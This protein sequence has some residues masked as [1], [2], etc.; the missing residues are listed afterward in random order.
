M[1]F[2]FNLY[3]FASHL[4]KLFDTTYYF[5][6]KTI[7]TSFTISASKNSD[8]W[9]KNNSYI[10]CILVPKVGLTNMP[11]VDIKRLLPYH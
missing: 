11:A 5:Y 9:S 2:I 10:F 7:I 1:L 4:P 6:K 8:N 3:G